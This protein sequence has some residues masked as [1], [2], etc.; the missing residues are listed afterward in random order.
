[1]GF[2]S[3]TPHRKNK[4]LKNPKNNNNVILKSYGVIIFGI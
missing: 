2:S 3:I 1:M 4:F